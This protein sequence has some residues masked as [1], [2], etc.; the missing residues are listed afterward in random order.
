M[1]PERGHSG[2]AMQMST[3]PQTLA[4]A[5]NDSPAGAAGLEPRRVASVGRTYD[6]C[7]HFASLEA[8]EE[9]VADIRAFFG[10]L[11]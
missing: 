11:R 4:Y 5:L 6:T 2:Y 1:L 10:S 3:R 8:P 9:L 7:G